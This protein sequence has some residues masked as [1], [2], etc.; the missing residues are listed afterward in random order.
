MVKPFNALSIETALVPSQTCN[1]TDFKFAMRSAFS[2]R[3]MK[4]EKKEFVVFLRHKPLHFRHLSY[5]L[6]SLP[7]ANLFCKPYSYY[8]WDIISFFLLSEM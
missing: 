7:Y 2:E 5:P 6:K 3:K 1:S 4:R 8:I